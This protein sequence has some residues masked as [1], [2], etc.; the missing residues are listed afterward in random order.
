[1]PAYFKIQRQE[2]KDDTWEIYREE[3]GT[4]LKIT[5]WQKIGEGFKSP[6]QAY[7]HAVGS[8]GHGDTLHRVHIV[9]K[10]E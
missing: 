8:E 10:K 2:G 1:M 9:N 3:K 7:D 5:D 6:G 4:D